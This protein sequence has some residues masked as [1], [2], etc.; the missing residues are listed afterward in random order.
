MTS[1]IEEFK[2]EF[3]ELCKKHNVIVTTSGYDNLQ[4]WDSKEKEDW[5][6]EYIEDMTE[7]D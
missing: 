2:K 1:K 7:N 5:P 3:I 4:V 6:Y